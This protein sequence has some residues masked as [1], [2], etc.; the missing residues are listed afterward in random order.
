MASDSFPV[1]QGSPFFLQSDISLRVGHGSILNR[2]LHPFDQFQLIAAVRRKI[3][4][5]SCLRKLGMEVSQIGFLANLINFQLIAALRRKMFKS[6]Y[7]RELNTPVSQIDFLAALINFQFIAAVR[8][9][10]FKSSYFFALST[11]VS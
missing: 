10:I 11:E 9:K 5:S 7:L 8:P 2:F 1:Y 3:L 6:S 4:K